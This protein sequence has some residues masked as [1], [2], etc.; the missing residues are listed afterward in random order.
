M[1]TRRPR[2]EPANRGGTLATRRRSRRASDGRPPVVA[3]DHRPNSG[4]R[5]GSVSHEDVNQTLRSCGMTLRPADPQAQ[6][7]A[8]GGP[9]GCPLPR[10]PRHGHPGLAQ[11]PVF[12]DSFHLIGPQGF[13]DSSRVAILARRCWPP[14]R[15]GSSGGPHR[16]TSLLSRPC[17]E[18]H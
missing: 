14:V 3:G 11:I 6:R 13:I 10:R 7:R 17:L 9:A 2:P 16:S 8:D 12:I 1:A 5:E 15:E 18:P 4:L